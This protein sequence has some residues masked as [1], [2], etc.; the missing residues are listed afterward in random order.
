MITVEL[1]EPVERGGEEAIEGR[2]VVIEGSCPVELEEGREIVKEELDGR[3][4]ERE[5][6]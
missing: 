5:G 2:S 1:T 3:S 6:D 4:E